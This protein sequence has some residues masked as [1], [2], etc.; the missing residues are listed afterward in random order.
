[1]PSVQI[2]EGYNGYIRSRGNSRTRVYNGYNLVANGGTSSYSPMGIYYVTT[3][4]WRGYQSYARIALSTIPAGA[5]ILGITGRYYLRV[6]STGSQ[7]F[8][9]Q[10][11]DYDWGTSV[12]TTDWIGASSLPGMK[13]AG[14]LCCEDDTTGASVGWNDLVIKPEFITR[15][16]LAVDADQTYFNYAWVSDDWLY[17]TNTGTSDVWWEIGDATV[18]EFTIEYIVPDPHPIFLGTVF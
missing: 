18:P 12:T 5:I 15:L 2:N 17:Y 16:Q 1:M 13:T 8:I 9:M 7:N 14:K 4:D 11:Y 10:M 6:D 3:L